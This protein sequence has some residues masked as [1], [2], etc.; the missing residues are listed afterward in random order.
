MFSPA[1]IKL[2]SLTRSP[3]AEPS[4]WTAGT[5]KPGVAAEDEA[6]EGAAFVTRFVGA[7]VV[8]L[9]R[10]GTFKLLFG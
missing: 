9:A 5:G 6:P 1:G 2:L 8:C 4:D 7:E 10:D 3:E